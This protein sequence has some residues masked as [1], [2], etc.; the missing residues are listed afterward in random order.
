MS[1]S[2]SSFMSFVSPEPNSGCWLWAGGCDQRG[3][4]FFRHRRAH[5]ISW[6]L[7]RGEIPAG[8]DVCHKCDNPAC[9]NPDHLWLGTHAENMADMRQKGRQARN[10]RPHTDE[11]K[12]KISSAHKGRS[13]TDEQRARLSA[14]NLGRTYPNRKRPES[15]SAEHRANLSAALKGV[16]KSEET[17]AR[18]REAWK[19]RKAANPNN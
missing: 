3:Y 5:R 4:G 11:A 10:Y 18:M 13:L 9:V 19:R 15:F 12:A 16:R 14:V 7:F 8:I 1:D 17:R 6:S 2:A